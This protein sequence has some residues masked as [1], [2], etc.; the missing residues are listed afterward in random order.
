[1]TTSFFVYT[2][3]EIIYLMV[4]FLFGVITGAALLNLSL[5]QQIDHLMLE[6]NELK[7]KIEEQLNTI[8][9]LEENRDKY[10]YIRK[11]SIELETDLNKHSQQAIKNKTRELLAGIVGKEIKNLDPL[12]LRDIVNDRYLLIEDKHYHLQ[13]EYLVISEEMELFLKVS[14]AKKIQEAE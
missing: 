14:T 1:L 4:I 8:K 3:N 10:N 13:L 7:V 2:K 12:L 6:K 11:I 9:Q 5:S